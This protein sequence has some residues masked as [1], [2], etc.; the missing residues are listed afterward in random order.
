MAASIF[1]KVKMAPPDPIVGLTVA[2][3]EDKDS[4]KVSLGVGAYRSDEGKPWVLPSVRKAEDMVVK[5][6]KIDKEYAPIDGLP[7][8]KKPVQDLIFSPDTV[9]SGRIATAQGLSGTGS[10]Q[11][12]GQ[13]LKEF[14]GITEVY[15][16]SPTWGNHTAIFKRAGLGVKTYTYY[17]AETKGLNFEG[18]LGDLQKIPEGLAV[19]LHSCAHNPTGVDPTPQ[20]WEKI[21]EVCKSRKLVP[22]IDNAYQGYAS[23]DLARDG[24]AQTLFEKSGMEYFLTQSFAKN[25]GLYGDRIGYMHV[26]CANKERATTVLSQLKIL[27]RQAYSSPPRHG[28]AIVNKLLTT[29]EL[30]KQWLEELKFMADRIGKMRTALRDAVEKLNTPGTWNHITDQIGMFTFTGLNDAQVKQMT[31]EWHIYLTKDGRISMAGVTTGNVGYVA[32]AINGVVT[33]KSRSKL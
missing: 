24:T 12:V 33:G 7:E 30:K 13:F 29:P 16:P 26:L 20:Q 31:E 17:K 14:L 5:D 2:F 4:R 15:V 6:P 28:A 9:A 23:G 10:L 11:I 1:D 3:K 25:F 32:E 27:I 8:Y 19:L 21:V 18:M 22:I